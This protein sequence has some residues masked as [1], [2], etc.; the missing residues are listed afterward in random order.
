[1]KRVFLVL[2]ILALASLACWMSGLPALAQPTTSA[3]VT[4][5]PPPVLP[6]NAPDP[7]KSDNILVSMYAQVLPGV[8][9]INTGNALGSG[10][11]FD[12]NGHIITNQHVVENNSE[13]EVDFASGYK[14]HGTV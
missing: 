8:V 2:S 12:G 11:V 6:N 3:P 5:A 13:V 14:T 9:S 1:M 10:W 4:M 7:A